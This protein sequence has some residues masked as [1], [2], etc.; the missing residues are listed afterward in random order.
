MREFIA[1]C[2]DRVTGT[3]TGFDRL[4]FRGCIRRISYLRGL[5]SLMS[6]ERVLLKDF[7]GWA[8]GLT[9]RIRDHLEGRIDGLGR[10]REYLASPGI[11]KEDVARKF[12]DES[13]IEAGPICLLSAVEPCASFEI[14]RNRARKRLELQPRVRKCLFYYLYFLDPRLGFGHVRLQTWLPFQVQVCLNGRE[15]LARQMDA[16][17]LGY[18]RADNVFLSLEDPHKAQRLMDRQ[19]RT[20]WARLLDRLLRLVHPLYKRL[21]ARS[22][23]AY[24]WSTHQMEWATDVYFRNA[25]D[26]EGLYPLWVRHAIWVARTCCASWAR[27]SLPPSLAR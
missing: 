24:Y 16:A 5:Q 11:R 7:G 12:L 19:L 22:Q 26:L 18:Q 13:P 1:R 14:H 3:L 15:W 10:P 9:K 27:N 4:L 25:Q 6:N 23:V 21:F 17:G 2:T 8:Q 20:A